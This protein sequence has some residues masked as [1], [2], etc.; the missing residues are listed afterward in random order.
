VSIISGEE[1][2]EEELVLALHIGSQETW[3]TP[4]I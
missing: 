2:K 1:K 3:M 4:Y